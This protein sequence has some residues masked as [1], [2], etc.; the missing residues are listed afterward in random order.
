MRVLVCSAIPYVNSTSIHFGNLIG[1]ALSA[2]IYARFRRRFTPHDEVI[3][4]G[5]GDCYGAATMISAA[6]ENCDPQTLCTRNLSR[7]Q[8]VFVAYGISTDIFSSTMNAQHAPFVQSIFERLLNAGYLSVREMKQ[9]YSEKSQMFLPDRFVGSICPYCN[10]Q[11]AK[12]DQ[13]EKCCKPMDPLALIDPRC[14]IDDSIP[15]I[16]TT[17]HY[18]L[19]LEPLRPALQKWVDANKEQ[20]SDNAYRATCA[21]LEH[22]LESRCIT[23]DLSWG[24]PVP[25]DRIRNDLSYPSP[26]GAP[27][28]PAELVVPVKT[29]YVW[30]DAIFCYL[31]FLQA[32]G[33]NVGDWWGQNRNVETSIAQFFGKDNIYFHTIL[34]PGILMAVSTEH[35]RYALVN[36]I[37]ATEYLNYEGSKFAKSRNYGVFCDAALT[38]QLSG[39]PISPDIWRYYLI[40]IRPETNDANFAWADFASKINEFADTVGNFAHRVMSF[41]HRYFPNLQPFP[42]FDDLP[43]ME[44]MQAYN[45][46]M[47]DCQQRQGLRLCLKMAEHGNNYVTRTEIWKLIRTDPT[48]CQIVMSGLLA[49]LDIIADMLS[50]FTPT[51]SHAIKVV[52]TT[53]GPPT[54]LIPKVTPQDVAQFKAR[55][56]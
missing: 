4:L 16:R 8:Q 6:K 48:Q 56:G 13:C 36:R 54:V 33:R 11:D 25:E 50:P 21:Y 29:F 38:L 7:L 3:F 18:F 10:A 45:D 41:R 31:S 43:I 46:A 52:I 49:I 37:N 5:G 19:D 51:I 12:G 39:Q 44:T 24:V 30:F 26:E 27:G 15:V 40:S 1:S 55:F 17:K 42:A 22:P 34:L 53:G 9:F 14:L 23:R 32:G 35:D 20:W 47:M 2:D 28:Q